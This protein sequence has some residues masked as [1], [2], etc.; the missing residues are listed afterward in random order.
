MMNTLGH[1]HFVLVGSKR[2][3]FLSGAALRYHLKPYSLSAFIGK[4]HIEGI[5]K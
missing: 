1:L 2:R 5:R 3:R 4:D